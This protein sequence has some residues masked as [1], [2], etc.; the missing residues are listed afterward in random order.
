MKLNPESFHKY[1][2]VTICA[3]QQCLDE[4]ISNHTGTISCT[5]CISNESLGKS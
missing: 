4:R 1:L 2:L 3:N 5:T